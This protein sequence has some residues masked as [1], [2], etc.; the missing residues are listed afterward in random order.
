MPGRHLCAASGAS[1]IGGQQ[2]LTDCYTVGAE[3]LGIPCHQ[4]SLP[5]HTGG[6]LLR[7]EVLGSL[8]Q[9]NGGASPAAMA[10]EDTRMISVP[11]IALFSQGIDEPREGLFGDAPP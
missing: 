5:P 10:P 7:G 1:V 9:A 11:R 8:G 4:E 6:S 3:S 2:D